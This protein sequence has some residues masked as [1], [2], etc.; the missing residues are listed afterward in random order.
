[1][2]QL[3]QALLDAWAR[4]APRVRADRLEARRRA[5]RRL[6]L[7]RPVR[8]WCLCIRASDP[9]INEFRAE[10]DDRYAYEARRSHTVVLTGEL[11]RMLC[12]GVSVPWPGVPVREAA[13][14]RRLPVRTVIG[15]L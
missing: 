11:V 8:P 7:A 4:V 10:I 5:A 12:R 3:D 14:M 2:D 13:A 6:S 15:K 9:R 1:M